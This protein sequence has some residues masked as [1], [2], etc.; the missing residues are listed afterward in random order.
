MADLNYLER[1]LLEGLLGMGGGYVLDFTD[2]TYAAFFRDFRI[3]IDHAKYHI[4]GTSKAKRMRAFWEVES[5]AVVG[6]V[7]KGLLDY[8][9]QTKPQGAGDAV[10]DKHWAIVHRLRGTKPDAVARTED[11]FL[12][13]QF[14][15]I[16]LT[17]L[18]LDGAIEQSIR[19][20]LTEAQTCLARKAPL[21]V[22]F[23]CGSTLE[24]LLLNAATKG[25][26]A[27]NQ[28][29]AAPKKD[30]KVLRFPD[31]SLASFI[32]AAHELGLLGLDVKKFSNALR[33]FRNYI[34][35]FEQAASRFDPDEHTAR[36]S[37]QVLQAAIADLSGAR[38]RRP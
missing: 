30:G 5:N 9:A 18:G 23:L 17:K 37:W 2:M 25:P 3:N 34:H 31:W 35:P 29:A 8:T 26:A 13:V 22:I 21:A 10:Q 1:K 33:D 24:G 28:A 12:S 19:Q 38:R 15:K 7:L 16:E 36:I 4:N 6:R 11:E 32:D 27:F 14:G 20:R